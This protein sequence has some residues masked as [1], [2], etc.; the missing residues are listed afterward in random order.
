M[1][2]VWWLCGGAKGWQLTQLC[3]AAVE[4]LVLELAVMAR[5]ASSTFRTTTHPP[6]IIFTS[7]PSCR[8]LPR[9]WSTIHYRKRLLVPVLPY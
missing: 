9:V 3:D 8:R 2:V 7:S 5:A 4:P 1:V 6:H